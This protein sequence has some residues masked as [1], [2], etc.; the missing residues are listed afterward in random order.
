MKN[1]KLT[2][3]QKAIPSLEN[4]FFKFAIRYP[5]FP[6]L[7]IVDFCYCGGRAERAMCSPLQYEQYEIRHSHKW[8]NE[9]AEWAAWAREW[10]EWVEHCGVNEQVEHCR[11][12]EWANEWSFS[13][14]YGPKRTRTPKKKSIT[15]LRS[16]GF[17]KF[18]GILKCRQISYFLVP[19]RKL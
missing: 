18:G 3:D 15:P 19:I 10:A 7:V 1:D 14:R 8:V 9:W 2:F 16:N 12:N 6:Y 11:A 17:G 13:T 4:S 5:H